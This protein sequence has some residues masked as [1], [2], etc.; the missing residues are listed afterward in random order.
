MKSIS[1][2]VPIY[3]VDQYLEA[4]IE[5]IMKQT[6]QNLEILLVNDCSTYN[7]GINSNDFSLIDSRIKVVHK[8]NEGVSSARNV[9]IQQGK[10]DYIA[11]IDPDHEVYLEMYENC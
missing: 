5:S 9:G 4:S 11:F 7:S 2:V 10:V 6:Y 1:I 8:K 3:N